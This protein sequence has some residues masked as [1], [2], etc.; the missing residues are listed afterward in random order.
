MEN[1]QQFQQNVE[2]LIKYFLI[3]LV[4]YASYL[5][6]KPFLLISIW[7]IILSVSFESFYLRINKLLKEKKKELV[8]IQKLKKRLSLTPEGLLF[9]EQVKNLKIK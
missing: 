9:L 5:I 7:A 1:S 3:S 2:Q 6:Y 8:E 4:I